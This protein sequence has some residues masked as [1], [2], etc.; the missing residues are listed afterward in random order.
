MEAVAGEEDEAIVETA[1]TA[2]AEEAT[3][4]VVEVTVVE[5]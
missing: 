5:G 3:D 2:E 4:A 1:A